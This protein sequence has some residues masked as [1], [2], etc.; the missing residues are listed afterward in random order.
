ME[1]RPSDMGGGGEYIEYAVADSRLRV[2][3]RLGGFSYVLTTPHHKNVRCYEA[4][5]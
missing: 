2:V 1:E 5:H 4:S 3:L